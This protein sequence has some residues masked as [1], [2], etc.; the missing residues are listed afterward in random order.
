MMF[1]FSHY[2]LYV[3]HVGLYSCH[4]SDVNTKISKLE[5]TRVHLATVSVLDSVPGDK[6]SV[7]TLVTRSRS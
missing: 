3:V 1:T 6:V 7:T 2:H 5:S 4:C